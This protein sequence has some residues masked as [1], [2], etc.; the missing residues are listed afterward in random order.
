MKQIQNTNL[1]RNRI[2]NSPVYKNFPNTKVVGD[3]TQL[4]STNPKYK[5]LFLLIGG[6]PCQNL[7]SR[8]NQKGL[9]GK[10]SSLFYEYVRVLKD[11]QPEFFLLENVGSM[12]RQNRDLITQEINTAVRGTEARKVKCIKINSSGFVPQNRRRYYWTNIPFRETELP[13]N[14]ITRS[15]QDILEE[16]V[17]DKYYYT[18]HNKTR[19]FLINSY[20]AK[21]EADLKIARTLKT[22]ASPGRAGADNCYHT[23]YKPNQKTNLR[24]LTPLEYE[25]LQGI[26]DNYTEGISNTQ[27]YKSIG[28]SFTVPVIKWFL[29]NIFPIKLN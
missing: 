8:G 9:K 5:N 12:S 16:K 29:K 18:E 4:V 14:P 24:K 1:Y 17:D 3:I 10:K 25:R 13:T 21:P 11:T 27:R 19:S 6:S 26:P 22:H 7:S 15:V 20:N 28:N 2:R 23:D